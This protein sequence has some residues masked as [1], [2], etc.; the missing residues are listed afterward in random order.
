ML[1]FEE[2]NRQV[3]S[4]GAGIFIPAAASRLVTRGQVEALVAGGL[5]VIACGANVPF[6]GPKIFF[7]AT[8]ELADAHAAIIPDFVADCGIA[9]VFANLMETGA[10]I[11]N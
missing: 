3:W 9:R 1:S 6:T 10:G 5:E 7:G 11:T 8:E 2:I 4:A